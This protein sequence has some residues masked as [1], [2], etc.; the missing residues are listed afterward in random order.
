MPMVIRGLFRYPH[1]PPTATTVLYIEIKIS[2][3]MVGRRKP[4][5]WKVNKRR[6]HEGRDR[7]GGDCCLKSQKK[8]FFNLE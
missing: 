1:I 3:D 2:R 8:F 5:A 7:N 6:R 4:Q